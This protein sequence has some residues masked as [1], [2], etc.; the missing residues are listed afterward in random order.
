MAEQEDEQRRFPRFRI[1]LKVHIRLSDG[2]IAVAKAT[3]LSMG[4]IYIEYAAAADVGSEFEMMFDLSFTSDFKRVFARGKV[5]RCVVVGGKDVYGIA[6]S[7]TGFG[8]QT[9]KILEQY[10]ELRQ[11]KQTSF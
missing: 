6:F 9:D 3:N 11:L 4:G 1:N 10:L 5:V 2:D 7:F 8:K